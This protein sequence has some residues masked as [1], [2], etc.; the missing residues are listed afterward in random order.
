LFNLYG[1]TAGVPTQDPAVPATHARGSV[2][3]AIS[4]MAAAT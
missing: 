4:V 1:P 2:D 3:T